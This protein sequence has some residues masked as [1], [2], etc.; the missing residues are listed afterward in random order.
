MACDLD[1]NKAVNPK[2]AIPKKIIILIYNLFMEGV[3]V[4]IFQMDVGI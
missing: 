4:R 3:G 1:L 2:T